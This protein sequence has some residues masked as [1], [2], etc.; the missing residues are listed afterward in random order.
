MLWMECVCSR[1][2]E[3]VRKG[4]GGETEKEIEKENKSMHILF[5]PQWEQMQPFLHIG[6]NTIS[7]F[8]YFLLHT[9]SLHCHFSNMLHFCT[10]F[11]KSNT[12]ASSVIFWV[13]GKKKSQLMETRLKPDV[14]TFIRC[15]ASNTV[16]N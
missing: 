15:S 9:V 8:I 12:M 2:R 5:F 16:T 1:S 3:G 4:G 10:C 14:P 7:V 11:N 6:T 13:V